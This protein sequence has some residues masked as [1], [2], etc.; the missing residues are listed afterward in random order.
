MTNFCC[1]EV[2]ELK[3]KQKEKKL[4]L[5]VEEEAKRESGNFDK[6]AQ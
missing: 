4:N 6:G 2:N 3:I 5:C 1:Y